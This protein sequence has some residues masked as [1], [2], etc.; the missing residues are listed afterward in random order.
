[1]NYVIIIRTV[2]CVDEIPLKFK[3]QECCSNIVEDYLTINFE[4][5]ISMFSA[6]TLFEVSGIKI[7]FGKVKLLYSNMNLAQSRSDLGTASGHSWKISERY[8]T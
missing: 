2:S 1:M 4:K 8:R 7:P 6:E 5:K 3:L